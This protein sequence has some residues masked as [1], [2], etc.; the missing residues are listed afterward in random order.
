M[1]INYAWNRVWHCVVIELCLEQGVIY[2]ERGLVEGGPT[3][4]AGKRAR[5]RLP[6]SNVLRWSPAEG[7][8]QIKGVCQ[9]TFN[10]KWP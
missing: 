1:V 2:Q 3:G 4:Q 10:P 6:S 8:V 5:V 7:V 9:H